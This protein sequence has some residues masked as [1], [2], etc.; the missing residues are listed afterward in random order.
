MESAEFNSTLFDNSLVELSTARTG[1]NLDAGGSPEKAKEG[2]PRS[3]ANLNMNRER[4]GPQPD[5]E[6]NEPRLALANRGNPV[7]SVSGRK[8]GTYTGGTSGRPKN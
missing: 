8:P 3:G 2:T 6:R 1:R 5:P 4:P 7:I